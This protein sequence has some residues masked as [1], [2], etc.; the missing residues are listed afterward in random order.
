[1]AY[2]N[3]RFSHD[4]AHLYGGLHIDHVVVYSVC[5]ISLRK[6][7]GGGSTEIFLVHTCRMRYNR[8]LCFTFHT[9]FLLHFI[10]C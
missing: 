4:M 9:L 2:A 6:Y 3:C 7:S 10:Y 1:M 8:F 5:G